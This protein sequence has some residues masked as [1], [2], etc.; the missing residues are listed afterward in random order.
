MKLS[1][2]EK[3][4][5]GVGALGKDLIYAIVSTYLMVYFTDVV[6]LAPLF[7][8]T[9]FLVARIWDAVNDPAM[10]MIVD[11]TRSKWGK[12]RP[13]ILIGTIINAIVTVFLFTKPDLSGTALYVYYSVVYI[14]WGMTYT[15]MDIPYWSMIPSLSKDKAEREKISVIPRIF[16]S[17]AWFLM[18]TVGFT[19][20]KYLGN[21]DEV[22]GYSVFAKIVAV[23][24]CLTSIITVLNT[25]E[26]ASTAKTAPTEKVNL[27]QTFKIIKQNDQLTVFIGIVLAYNLLTQLV[28]G[29]AIY[30]FKYVLEIENFY[31]VFNGFASM[32]EITGLVLFP[33]LAQRIG[34]K[35]VFKIG[36]GLPGVGLIM[37][38]IAGFVMPGNAMFVAVSGFLFKLGSGFALGTT[39][40][41]LADV[42]DY[43]EFK[44]GTRNESIIFSCQTLLV[45]SASAISGWL[46]GVGLTVIGYQAN[47][48][49]SD[50][51]ILGM[52]II[53]II[54]PSVLGL[55][56][57]FIY[58]RY[59]KLNGDY[60]DEVLSELE[61]R[62]KLATA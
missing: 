31:M 6:G 22:V 24:F 41:M 37:L 56:S 25:K 39:T 9:L 46:I 53:M 50:A 27:K 16:A 8:G 1:A 35:N 36:A 55:L 13:W 30:Y 51:T 32:A 47:V 44:L 43:G 59:Y 20:P 48:A 14:L 33:I 42:V 60:H 34:R 29:M 21:G 2:R 10:G 18:G 3:Y 26:R 57:F 61:N 45:K 19:L 49:Q 54:I 28:G 5:Y 62:N 7:I 11:N 17:S 12:F 15:I 58:K 38:L 4:S 40:V 23:I 52:R